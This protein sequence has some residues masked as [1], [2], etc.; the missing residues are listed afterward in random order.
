M[1]SFRYWHEVVLALL[2]VALL[3]VAHFI[4]PRFLR[5]GTQIELSRHLWEIALLALPMMLIIITAGIDLS[6]GS[7]MA[8]CAVA[9]GMLYEA[10]VPVWL[11]CA[12]ALLV[13][14]LNH[15]PVRKEMEDGAAS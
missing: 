7:N 10:H 4:E 13:G 3:C 14:L 15:A 8:M 11:A 9:L 12:A 5:I 2:L 6:V 1:K